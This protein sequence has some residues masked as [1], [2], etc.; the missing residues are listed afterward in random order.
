MANITNIKLGSNDQNTIQF[1]SYVEDYDVK[2][3]FSDWIVSDGCVVDISDDGMTLTIKKFNPKKYCIKANINSFTPLNKEGWGNFAD[4]W[5][6]SLNGVANTLL[7]LNTT[8]ND[9]GGT[10]FPGCHEIV[11]TGDPNSKYYIKGFSLQPLDS[12]RDQE[13]FRQ[14]PWDMGVHGTDEYGGRPYKDWGYGSRNLGFINDG[15]KVR[16]VSNK[17]MYYSRQTLIPCIGIYGYFTNVDSDG[18]VDISEN[19]IIIKAVKEN[20]RVD[21]STEECWD[22]YLKDTKIY[23]KDKT[24]ENCWKKFGLLFQ[25]GY[26]YVAKNLN[27]N[28]K[29]NFFQQFSLVL[30]L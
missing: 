17:S 11:P 3:L 4:P 21:P 27:R 20:Y 7:N 6:L 18:F 14:Y 24:K 15:E 1:S 13:L 9:V 23:H 5:Y 2:S 29:P 30:S 10:D 19:P 22:A 12:E 26:L 16:V 8:L 25:E 28:D